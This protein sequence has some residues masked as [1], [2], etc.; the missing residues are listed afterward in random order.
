MGILFSSIGQNSSL[1]LEIPISVYTPWSKAA[2]FFGVLYIVEHTSG[3]KLITMTDSKAG[4]CSDG[5][6][7][8]VV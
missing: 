4:R 7:M 1:M 3:A 5:M 8:S 2:N 6:V